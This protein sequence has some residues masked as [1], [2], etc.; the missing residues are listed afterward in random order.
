[1][2]GHFPSPFTD[3]LL[4]SICARFKDRMGYPVQQ[5]ANREL[6]G[7]TKKAVV[8]LPSHLGYLIDALPRGH[9][10]TVER[11]IQE[12]TLFPYYRP[13]LSPERVGR[14]LECMK[15]SG[16]LRAKLSSGSASTLGHKPEWLRFCPLCAEEDERGFG[17]YWRRLHQA[18][19]VMVCPVHCVFLENSSASIRHES[20]HNKFVSAES[21]IAPTKAR[22]LDPSNRNHQILLRIA[23]DVAWLLEQPDLVSDY[24]VLHKRY[25]SLL[26]NTKFGT[27]NGWVRG[28]KIVQA[29]EDYYSVELLSF[30]HYGIDKSRHTS[31]ATT[32]IKDLKRNHFHHPLQH[33]LWIQMLGHTAESFFSMNS[34]FKPFGDG[35]WPCL[36]PVCDQFKKLRVTNCRV[37]V[38]YS[39]HQR[40]PVGTFT[41]ECGFSYY[42]KGPDTYPEDKYRSNKV[43]AYG[44]I[45]DAALEESWSDLAIRAN[46]I[47]LRL[48]L[49]DTR[50]NT[51]KR[52]AARLNLPFPRIVPG[53]PP[54]LAPKSRS[55]VTSSIP[56]QM[57]QTNEVSEY[58]MRWLSAM[59]QYPDA[60]RT[61]LKEKFSTLYKWL[62]RNDTEWLLLHLPPRMDHS[63][64]WEAL[65]ARLV[66]WVRLSAERMKNSIP[67]HRVTVFS[68]G[69][70]TDS[71]E[72]LRKCLHKLPQTATVLNQVVETTIDFAQR[73]LERAAEF[74]KAE[75]II[76]ARSELIAKAR[77][78]REMKY[79]P[80][81]QPFIDAL[82]ERDTPF[83]IKQPL[84]STNNIL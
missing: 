1:M 34:E 32:F 40:T 2:I 71:Y 78:S 72:Y 59:A 75:G 51:I 69:K 73:Q 82:L 56:D 21:A 30:L 18:S 47:A 66:E 42:R 46:E 26:G 6:F 62:A 27:F 11:L 36:N 41:C 57:P 16:A 54:L 22:P 4:Y 29:F 12:H 80:E 23:R 28:P 33:L 58:R 10:F 70:D 45:W 77:L 31:W 65:D 68:I 61:V 79:S 5:D 38:S 15:G 44:K 8:D 3:E 64:D 76:P 50:V 35:P 20:D 14:V 67:L 49:K 13:F 24:S 81:L 84:Y 83:H 19:G 63:F 53:T 60:H 9:H 52:E 74:F 37:S 17:K 48:C 55:K 25:I 43:R 7:C 39:D